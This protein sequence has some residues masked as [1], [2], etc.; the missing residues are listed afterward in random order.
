MLVRCSMFTLQCRPLD[1]R[2]IP[3]E[4][5][6]CLWYSI[7]SP[8]MN[9]PSQA[10]SASIRLAEKS[11]LISQRVLNRVCWIGSACFG[12]YLFG[13][14]TGGFVTRFCFALAGGL[15]FGIVSD[16]SLSA[17]ATIFLQFRRQAC[18]HQSALLQRMLWGVVV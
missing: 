4:C 1:P 13:S 14:N 5:L 17:L 8:I 7:G 18:D 3:I 11:S 15:I 2:S 10:A 9:A 6:R 16:A 12:V